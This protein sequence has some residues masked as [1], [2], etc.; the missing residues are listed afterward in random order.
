MPR[1]IVCDVNET[2]LDVGALEPDFKEVFGDGRVLQEWF[3]TVLLYSEV[4]TLAGPYT[5]FAS[6][7]G[8]ALDM[9]A[10]ARNVTVAPDN[11]TRIL[12][13]MLKLPAHPDVREGLQIMR[14]AGL[15]LVTLTNSAPAAVQQQLANA[16]LAALFERSFSVDTV[17]RFKPAPEA[18]RAVADELGVPVDQLRLVAAHAWDIVGALRAGCAAAFVA[19]PGKVL[20]PLGPKPDVV[21]PDFRRVAQQIIALEKA[22]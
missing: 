13:G 5:D 7:A 20:Y 10:T 16:G 3:A 11:R 21:G 8:A 19:R 6:I 4:A 18:Y 9:I 2:L 15:R 1:V 17:R 12:Q 22:V 14:D